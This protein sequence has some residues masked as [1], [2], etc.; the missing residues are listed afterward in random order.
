MSDGTTFRR[1]RAKMCLL[2]VWFSESASPAPVARRA[3]I[4]SSVARDASAASKRNQSMPPG[5][6]RFGDR[7]LKQFPR[8]KHLLVERG[9][10]SPSHA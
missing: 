5:T 4:S 10:P 1:V 8:A 9:Q 3:M 6:L 7:R 2:G